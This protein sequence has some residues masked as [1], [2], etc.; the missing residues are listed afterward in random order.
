MRQR[1]PFG[2]LLFIPYLA[3][4]LLESVWSLRRRTRFELFRGYISHP[5]RFSHHPRVYA[6]IDRH[7]VRRNWEGD[8]LGIAEALELFET[9]GMVAQN[10]ATHTC[11]EYG[12]DLRDLLAIWSSARSRGW[13]RCGRKC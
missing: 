6:P 3:A 7:D 10:L 1:A 13:T 12:R 8:D 2:S 11:Y 5:T 4:E 9:I